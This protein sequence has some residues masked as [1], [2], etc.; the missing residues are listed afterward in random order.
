M[1]K[2]MKNYKGKVKLAYKF[3]P[4][5][6]HNH[7]E[8]AARAAIAAKNQGKFWEMHDILFANQSKLGPDFFESTAK[9]LDLD[10]DKFKADMNSEQTK[11][12]VQKD[13]ALGRKNGI[14][15]TPGFFVN[16]VAVKGAYPYD[17]FKTIIDR[18]L[19]QG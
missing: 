11:K 4:L 13:I 8:P 14:Q 5:P 17:Y 15:G 18:W 16:G 2:V 9:K 10:M 3:F 6:F 19:K 7:A 12:I 1:E